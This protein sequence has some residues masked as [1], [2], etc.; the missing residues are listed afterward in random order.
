MNLDDLFK[1]A[2]IMWKRENHFDNFKTQE[3]GVKMAYLERVEQMVKLLNEAGFEV[4]QG[5][6]NVKSDG[7]GDTSDKERS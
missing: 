5:E 1:I 2:S 3:V 4:V 6:G 7:P